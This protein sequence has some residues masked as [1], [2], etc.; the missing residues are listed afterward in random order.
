[1]TKINIGTREGDIVYTPQLVT[2][3]RKTTA[4]AARQITEESSF[5]EGDVIGVLNRYKRYVIERLKDGYQVELLGFG[6]IYNKALRDKGVDSEKEVTS[7][8]IKR[9]VPGFRPGFNVV[10]GNRIYTLMPDKIAL[11]KADGTGLNDDGTTDDPTETP[12]P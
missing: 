4:D 5:T 11:V 1:M 6:T 8:L 12:N 10:N 9:L 3:G 2:Y 7:K